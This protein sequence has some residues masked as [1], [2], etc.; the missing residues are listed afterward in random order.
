[1][2]QVSTTTSTYMLT[3]FARQDLSPHGKGV[4][5]TLS[6]T[7]FDR[8]HLTVKIYRTTTT[9]G[10]RSKALAKVCG[11]DFGQQST[12]S[13]R[14]E[15]E[16]QAENAGSS[17][18]QRGEAP[19]TVT[20]LV[21]ACIVLPIIPCTL[22][23]P[24]TLRVMS[25]PLQQTLDFDAHARMLANALPR[26]ELPVKATFQDDIIGFCFLDTSLPATSPY[27]RFQMKFPNR[28]D[29]FRFLGEIENVCPYAES[30]VSPVPPTTSTISAEE[31]IA[32]ELELSAAAYVLRPVLETL[33]LTSQVFRLKSRARRPEAHNN[34][35]AARKIAASHLCPRRRHP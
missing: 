7:F 5:I 27:R 26:S 11:P 31:K 20:C 34:K 24:M 14:L 13:M 18:T 33:L 19:S 16:W 29:M 23:N 4:S 30:T 6:W 28:A 12:S 9:P 32:G 10:P 2:S 22:S 15:V 17:Q 8:P 21:S 3:K 25:F 35:T 1:M